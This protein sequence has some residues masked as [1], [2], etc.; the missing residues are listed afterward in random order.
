MITDRYKAH[1]Q[2]KHGEKIHKCSLCDHTFRS[3][4]LVERHM[5]RLHT[6]QMVRC[7]HCQY[8]TYRPELIRRHQLLVHGIGREEQQQ[9]IS[10]L[11]RTDSD[12]FKRGKQI[13]GRP[14][15]SG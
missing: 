14:V 15:I 12:A 3:K 10:Q 4:N 6:Q 8:Q 2:M 9:L 5:A 11:I 7:D 1:V 13:P